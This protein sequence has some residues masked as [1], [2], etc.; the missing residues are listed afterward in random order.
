M[1]E[2]IIII[3]EAGVNHNGKLEIA[4]ELIDV[5]AAAGAD[6]VK[7]QT[8]KAENLLTEYA[9][10]APYQKALTQGDESQFEMIK[11]LELSKALHM[12]LRQ[13]CI[14]KGIR[15][16][17]SPFDIESLALLME[18]DVDFIK[19]PSGEI[20]NYPLLR[21]IGRTGK[22]VVL[23]TGM[24]NIEDVES[25]VRVLREYGATEITLLQCNTEY[26]TPYED[27]NLKAM[28]TL[29][30]TF[31]MPVGYSDHSLG[32]EVP[33][34]AA[35]RGAVII[36]KHFTVDKTL[37]GPDHQASLEPDELY[38]MVKAIRNIE[39]CIGTGEKVPSASEVKNVSAARKSIVASRKIKSGE[40]FSE[41]NLTVKRPGTGVSPMRWRDVVGCSAKKDFEKD[42][43]IEI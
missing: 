37:A 41:E 8:F 16:M 2:N 26:P 15:F 30:D 32:I 5:A 36:E 28:D 34:A 39:L 24:S 25:A 1:T 17:S 40:I 31:Q 27:V 43:M 42:E 29:K 38:H 12:S 9:Q 23:S 10:K 18:L 19:I 4:K 6:Y 20:V 13:Y 14:E 11:K 22:P 3:A 35:A 33:I 7:F 21:E